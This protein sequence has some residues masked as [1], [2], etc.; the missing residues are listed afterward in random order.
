MSETGGTWPRQRGRRCVYSQG[1]GSETRLCKDL[2][3]KMTSSMASKKLAS[4][5]TV[6]RSSGCVLTTVKKSAGGENSLWFPK[7]AMTLG[8]YLLAASLCSR[9]CNGARERQTPPASPPGRRRRS[10]VTVHRGLR[11]PP[12]LRRRF[13]PEEQ[14]HLREDVPHHV[15]DSHLQEAE[16]APPHLV[17]YEQLWE[18]YP[19]SKSI[20]RLCLLDLTSFYSICHV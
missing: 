11:K 17:H 15:K 18:L 2:Q 8:G 14:H 5:T 3:K 13:S 10:D 9:G 1:R 7:P 19:P 4:S 12:V 16:P 6:L 20:S